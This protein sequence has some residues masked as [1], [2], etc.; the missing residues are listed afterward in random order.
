MPKAHQEFATWTPQRIISWAAQTG[1]ATAQVVETILSRKAY[2]EHGFR[3]CMGIIS[4]A[5]RYTS[6]RLESA[7]TRALTIKGISYR[8]IKSILENNLDQHLLP[9]QTDLLPLVR[10]NIRGTEYYNDERKQHAHP[11]DH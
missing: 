5:K 2:P 11:T 9:R 8:S 3:S 7:C 4:L 1:P 6:Q 10:D